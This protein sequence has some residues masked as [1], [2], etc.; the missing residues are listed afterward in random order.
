MS[1]YA[2]PEIVNDGLIGY[3][4][5][6]SIKSYLGSGSTWYD[7]SGR[8]NHGTISGT[9]LTANPPVFNGTTNVVTCPTLATMCGG[10]WSGSVSFDAT[11]KIANPPTNSAMGYVGF[12]SSN[13]GLKFMNTTNL[14]MD[15]YDSS[16][17]R[18]LV[19]TIL[20]ISSYY[21]TWVH[22]CATYD[23]T[24]A[25]CYHNGRF[26]SQR[27]SYTQL[28]LSTMNYYIGAGM[29][30]YNFMGSVSNSKVYNKALT[31]AEV[32][33]NFNAIRGRFNV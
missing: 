8:D 24:T 9:T 12:N 11:F 17:L 10:S 29:G 25:K 19:N 13:L 14:F 7:L 30:Y 33:Q 3:W 1:V 22:V 26:V 16:S 27:A 5:S 21:D 31:D 28:D 15:T 20:G 23:G 32:Q 18:V 2:G 6:S 4:D